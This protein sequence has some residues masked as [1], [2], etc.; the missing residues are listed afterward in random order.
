M[1]FVSVWSWAR[2]PQGASDASLRSTLRVS[3]GP[4]AWAIHCTPSEAST[5]LPPL[6]RPRRWATVLGSP[7]R[8]QSKSTPV[9][10][11]PTRGDP[12][13]LAGRRLN[14]SAKVSL[15]PSSIY[16]AQSVVAAL[17]PPPS[18]C[19]GRYPPADGCAHRW[20]LPRGQ[21]RGLPLSDAP[22]GGMVLAGASSPIV[23]RRW[24]MPAARISVT[25]T[26]GLVTMTSASHAEGRQFDPGQVYLHPRL[27]MGDT[28]GHSA[29]GR[30]RSDML[31][32][33]SCAP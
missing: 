13:G 27:R 18:R 14:R 17:P 4:E 5:P 19:A 25:C 12:I 2:S 8:H 30:G 21:G 31:A 11:E 29:K 24:D 23:L 32:C 7:C 26:C 33:A 1:R 16:P 28:F 6:Q 10:F 9:G 22:P 15:V 3:A 20:L